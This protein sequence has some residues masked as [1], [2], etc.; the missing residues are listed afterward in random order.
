[1]ADPRFYRREGPFALSHLADL[2]GLD[3][4][5]ADLELAN[6]ASLELAER[7]ALGFFF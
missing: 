3:G 4:V 1:M 6:I 5:N 2:V 7:D